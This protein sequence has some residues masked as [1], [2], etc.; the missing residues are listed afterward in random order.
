MLKMIFRLLVLTI[1]YAG[2]CFALDINVP[3]NRPVGDVI[4]QSTF[5]YIYYEYNG[6]MKRCVGTTWIQYYLYG[7]PAVWTTSSCS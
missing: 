1:L 5:E 3:S 6:V 4:K 7:P 2:N